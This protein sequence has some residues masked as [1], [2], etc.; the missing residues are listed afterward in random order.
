[1]NNIVIDSKQKVSTDLQVVLDHICGPMPKNRIDSLINNDFSDEYI[2][3]TWYNSC[4]YVQEKSGAWFM[5]YPHCDV[6][7]TVVIFEE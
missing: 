5:A 6:G 2:R 7:N 1:M 3:T 4:F